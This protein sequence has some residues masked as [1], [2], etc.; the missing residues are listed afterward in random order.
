M[1]SSAL[2]A[3][4]LAASPLA[5]AGCVSDNSAGS[6]STASAT[7]QTGAKRAPGGPNFAAEDICV[8]AVQ[9]QTNA[10]GVGVI[11]SEFSQ[12]ATLVM[13][14]FPA[15]TAPWRCLVSPDGRVTEVKPVTG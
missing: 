1:K 6:V 11:S 8:K 3:A 12:A 7:A 13:L 2:L 9:Q 5:L 10:E 14:D 4:L 15:A